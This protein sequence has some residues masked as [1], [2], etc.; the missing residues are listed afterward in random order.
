MKH[1]EPLTADTPKRKQTR[2]VTLPDE[3]DQVFPWKPFAGIDRAH[4]I[5]KGEGGRPCLSAG[6]HAAGSSDAETGLATADS[7]DGGKRALYETD[8]LAHF[9]GLQLDSHFPTKPTIL[10]FR[11]FAGN[12][13]AC[14]RVASEVV[15][16]LT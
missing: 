5:P 14:H 11:R 13:T 9:A 15:N 16:P 7:G 3:M 8:H 6:S 2:P 12:A 1:D 4:F 10:N